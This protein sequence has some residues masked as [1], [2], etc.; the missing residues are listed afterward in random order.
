MKIEIQEEALKELR[1][2]IS[3]YDEHHQNLGSNFLVE[4]RKTI[5]SIL[6]N[7]TL[8]RIIFNSRREALVKRFPYIIVYSIE[9]ENVIVVFA[10]FH[11]SRNPKQKLRK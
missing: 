3:W 9:N 6:K 1:N 11:T 10:F 7:P 8:N 4:I 2:A 5:L